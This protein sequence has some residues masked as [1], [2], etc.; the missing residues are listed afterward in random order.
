MALKAVLPAPWYWKFM[1]H[2]IGYFDPELRLLP[3]FA[4]KRRAA[5]DVG[6]SLG[7]YAAHLLAHFGSC[8]AFEPRPDAA[9]FIA[10]RLSPHPD[11]RLSIENVALSD[12]SGEETLRVLVGD[13]GRSSIETSNPVERA[14]AVQ[15]LRVP[16]RRLD[17]YRFPMPVG[18]VKVDV[19][20]HEEAVLRGAERLLRE[21][22]PVLI[23]EI[24]ERH[25]PG[26][27]GAVS[28]FLE[29]LGY[30]G[31]F[32]RGQ[33]LLPIR[34]FDA[35]LHQVIGNI[36]YDAGTESLYVNNFI[37]LGPE[38]LAKVSHLIREPG[39]PGCVH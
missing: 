3:Y 24:E 34:T 1:A 8:Y 9:A 4:D 14:G 11:P 22:H 35:G 12:H 21:H 10:S 26:S 17:D 37:F 39:K 13:A 33:R 32:F 7:S 25:K 15:I 29:G 27:V 30:Q 28:D 5:I 23:V 2:R 16:V 19:E 18:C 20:G 36:R 31:Y 38:S 6:A